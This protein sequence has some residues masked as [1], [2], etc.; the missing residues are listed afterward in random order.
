LNLTR[1]DLERV[2]IQIE[3]QQKNMEISVMMNS[4]M[5]KFLDSEIAKLP[6]KDVK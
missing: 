3:G 5:L 2:K 1:E 4:A 6:K